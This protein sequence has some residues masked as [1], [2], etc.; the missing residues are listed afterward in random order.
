MS[1]NIILCG[2]GYGTPTHHYKNSEKPKLHELG[3]NGCC[4]K[5][6]EG[7]LIPTNFREENDSQVCDVNGY[8]ITTYTLFNQRLYSYHKDNDVWS[9]PKNEESTNSLPDNF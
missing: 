1:D 3:K 6:A 8:T 2:C 7:N 5:K 9:L 4:R